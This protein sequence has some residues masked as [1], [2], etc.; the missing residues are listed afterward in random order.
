MIVKLILSVFSSLSTKWSSRNGGIARPGSYFGP[1]YGPVWLSNIT[2]TGEE[3]HLAQ[4]PHAPWGENS[5][6]HEHDVGVTCFMEDAGKYKIVILSMPSNLGG[7]G[8]QVYSYH[9]LPK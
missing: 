9:R 5:C 7:L 3:E 1:G 2:C 4:C 8:I 6:T